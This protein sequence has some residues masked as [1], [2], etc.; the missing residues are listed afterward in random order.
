[1]TDLSVR[2]E[3]AAVR[4]CPD[5]GDK[6]DILRTIGRIGQEWFGGS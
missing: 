1:M 2:L 3:L 5:I 4:D 6:S